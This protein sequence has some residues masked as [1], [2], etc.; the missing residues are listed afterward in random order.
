MRISS[1]I[2]LADFIIG[3]SLI[4][5]LHMGPHQVEATARRKKEEK[6]TEAVREDDLSWEVRCSRRGRARVRF[7]PV[8]CHHFMVVPNLEDKIL[9]SRLHHLL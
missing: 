4:F 2:L 3:R 7:Q 1:N 5:G 6:L 8:H 9:R